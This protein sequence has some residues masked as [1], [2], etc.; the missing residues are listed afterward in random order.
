[1]AYTDI[2]SATRSICLTE[3]IIH[4]VVH[5]NEQPH[6]DARSHNDARPII[7]TYRDILLRVT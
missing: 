3:L 5:F 6:L 7:N 1:M 2:Q 4:C